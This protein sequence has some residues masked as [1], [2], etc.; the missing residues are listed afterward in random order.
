HPHDADAVEFRH[1]PI[2]Q[3]EIRALLFDERDGVFPGS[4]LADDCD[5]VKRAKQREEK[6]PRR[7]LVVGDDDA[8]PCAHDATLSISVADVLMASGRRSSRRVPA[9]GAVWIE[10]EPAG[11][12]WQSSRR[13]TLRR[14]TPAARPRSSV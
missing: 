3:G 6:R 14:P 4:G 8:E 10:S 5:V 2:E 11:P 9:P 13:S 12:Y 1:L 7:A